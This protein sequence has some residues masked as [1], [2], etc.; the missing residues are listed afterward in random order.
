MVTG[1][2][3]V[4]VSASAHWAGDHSDA[5]YAEESLLTDRMV[6]Q[7]LADFSTG[8]FCAREALA[9][10]GEPAQ[11]IPVG[12]DRQPVWPQ[13]FR[14]SISHSQG[15]VLA[16]VT[17]SPECL[18]IGIDAEVDTVLEPA[19]LQMVVTPQERARYG[20]AM[21]DLGCLLFSIKESVFKACFPLTRQWID[22]QD[23]N[24]LLAPDNLSYTV[25]LG[26]DVR[27]R[28]PA[29]VHLQGRCTRFERW[30][31]TTCTVLC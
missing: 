26:A 22:F 12:A 4:A 18:G 24:V 10:L 1:L 6:S 8:R 14:G 16:V 29:A 25:T 30:H 15:L 27:D 11:P 19:V 5:L 28:L 9:D 3:P 2:F 17:R 31:L 21:R 20:V 7:R 23:A 13:G